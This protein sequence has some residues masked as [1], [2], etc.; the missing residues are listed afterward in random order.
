MALGPWCL[1]VSSGVETEGLK[2][3]EKM[4]AFAEAFRQENKNIFI[5]KGAVS[6][7][8]EDLGSTEDSLYRRR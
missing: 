3:E 6:W 4:R 8:K 2:D 5:Y 1:D 7:E